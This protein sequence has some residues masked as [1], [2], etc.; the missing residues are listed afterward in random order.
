MF[1]EGTDMK[2]ISK[3][4]LVISA[5]VPTGISY[6]RPIIFDTDM[7]LYY[8]DTNTGAS[9]NLTSSRHDT[10]NSKSTFLSWIDQQR[11][12]YVCTSR[13]STINIPPKA[14]TGSISITVDPGTWTCSSFNDS[15]V[16]SIN[17]VIQCKA[18]GLNTGTGTG[19]SRRATDNGPRKY[20]DR[21]HSNSALC[22]ISIDGAA[23]VTTRGWL[24]N[25]QSKLTK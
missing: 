8:E 9:I 13:D 2:T 10:E 1:Q 14:K 7:S 23:P 24:L 5:M 18:D 20:N 15:P 25:K 22:Q 17:L 6:A 11:K 16:P 19:K 21:Y 12:Y 4:A 3:L